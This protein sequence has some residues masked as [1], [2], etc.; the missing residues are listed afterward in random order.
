MRGADRDAVRRQCGAR[1]V[2]H[3]GTVGR[4]D[5]EHRRLRG[6]L[7]PDH[8][9][10]CQAGV[11]RTRSRSA[12]SSRP[13]A[14]TSKRWRSTAGSRCSSAMSHTETAVSPWLQARAARTDARWVANSAATSA[15]SP[16]RSGASTVAYAVLDELDVDP[17]RSLAHCPWAPR[18]RPTASTRPGPPQ[19]PPRASA[20]R[21]PRVSMRLA[22]HEDQ[23]FGAVARASASVR[24]RS[25]FSASRSET[26]SVTRR[27][28]AG[29][30]GS[31]E[32][33]VSASNRCQRTRVPTRPPTARR[34]PARS[35]SH[36]TAARRRRC[37]R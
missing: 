31:R 8:H 24:A 3:A 36:G 32:L 29:S 28:V 6:R 27:T 11:E 5:L 21:R 25:R 30:S 12:G 34:I 4:P 26:R 18:P 7:R 13:D 9:R 10:R 15:S 35:R 16:T 19:A 20:A 22:R 23:A 1:Q 33:A 14:I 2:E 37:A 17:G